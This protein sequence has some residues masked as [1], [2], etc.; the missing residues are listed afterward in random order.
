MN[1][2]NSSVFDFEIVKNLSKKELVERFDLFWR[3]IPKDKICFGTL[4]LEVSAFER[5]QMESIYNGFIWD[6]QIR[7]LIDAFNLGRII[8]YEGVKRRLSL[9][10]SNIELVP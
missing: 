7:R 3:S 9:G 8:D 10:I 6:E 2:V 5:F 1:I 4:Q